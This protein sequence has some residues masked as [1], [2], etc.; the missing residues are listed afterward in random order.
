MSV[1]ELGE[2]TGGLGSK[3]ATTSTGGR[4]YI[5]S[6][7]GM[8]IYGDLGKRLYLVSGVIHVENNSQFNRRMAMKTVKATEEKGKCT[9]Q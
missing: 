1:S 3:W 2:I 5:G 4:Y 8:V 6:V 9:S 7:M